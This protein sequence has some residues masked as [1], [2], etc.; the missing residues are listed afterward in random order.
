MT[1]YTCSD[2]RREYKE[3]LGKK[4]VITRIAQLSVGYKHKLVTVGY[5][6]RIELLVTVG[7][8]E[9]VRHRLFRDQIEA[10]GGDGALIKLCMEFYKSRE[11]MDLLAEKLS[12]LD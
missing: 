3:Y 6:E 5:I 4:Y 1:Q 2:G 8:F 12:A 7:F 9:Y 11:P 10:I